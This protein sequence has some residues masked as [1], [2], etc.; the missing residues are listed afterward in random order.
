M[1][2]DPDPTFESALR[3]LQRIVNDLER[4]EPELSSALAKYEQG[5]KLLAQC[6]RVLE[7]AEKAVSLLT[8]VQPDGSPITS[9]FDET[10]PAEPN[11]KPAKDK[12]P[13]KRAVKPLDDPNDPFIPF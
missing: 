8:G 6:Q 1:S 2:T 11:P 9:P 5:V 12:T 3:D 7:Q 10:A 13:K 4:G